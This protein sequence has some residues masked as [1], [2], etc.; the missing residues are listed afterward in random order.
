M[1]FI[2]TLNYIQID[3]LSDQEKKALKKL[4][5]DHTTDLQAVI[6]EINEVINKLK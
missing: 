3:E 6:A 5:E 1:A 4:L 2:D